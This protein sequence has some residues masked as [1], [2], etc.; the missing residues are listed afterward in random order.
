[1]FINGGEEEAD[2]DIHG[3]AGG[4]GVADAGEPIHRDGH[5]YKAGGDE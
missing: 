4:N 3:V 5:R 1:M 2:E